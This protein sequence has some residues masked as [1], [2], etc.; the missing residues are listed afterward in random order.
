MYTVG[1]HLQRIALKPSIPK[2]SQHYITHYRPRG[3]TVFP[4]T[5]FG[6]HSNRTPSF[7]AHNSVVSEPNTQRHPL[8]KHFGLPKPNTQRC[9][10]G[11]Q[12]SPLQAGLAPGNS[13]HNFPV[14]SADITNIGSGCPA[15]AGVLTP[16][17]D[18]ITIRV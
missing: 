2:S 10:Q 1:E 13:L 15:R 7:R 14:S 5:H 12:E 17:S 4:H 16:T 8:Y 18:T 9:L 3:I 11:S 6:S